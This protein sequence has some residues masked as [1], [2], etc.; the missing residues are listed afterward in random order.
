MAPRSS[1]FLSFAFLSLLVFPSASAIKFNLPTSRFPPSKCIWNPAHENALVIVTAN[2]GP[3]AGQRVDIEII[4]SSP[5]KNVYLSKRNINAET[6]LA[7]TTHA[8][9]EVGVCFKN[10]LDKEISQEKA[11]KMSRVVDL[12]VDIGA[13]AVDYNAIA[14]QES[15]SGLETEM[16]KLEGLV[17]EIVDEM[18]YLK[19]RE[20]RFSD[21]NVST[22]QRVQNFAWFTIVSLAGLGPESR[23]HDGA[24]LGFI[25]AIAARSKPLNLPRLPIP[26]LRQTL[27]R[28]LKSLE[29]F[30]LEDEARGGTSFSSAYALRVKWANEFESGVGQLCQ[31]RLLALDRASPHNWLDDNF[32]MNKAY[33]EWRAPLLV[34]SNW[35][36]A[37]E[38][39]AM[40][41]AHARESTPGITPWQVRRAAWLVH[42]L[43]SFKDGLDKQ[44]LYPETTRLGLWLRDS[45]AKMFNMARIPK[46]SCDILSKPPSAT[47]PDG[48]KI[49][50]MIHNWCYAMPIYEL[51]S[52]STL[53]DVGEIERRMRSIVIDVERRLAEGETAFP[54]GVLTA[55][56]RDRWTENL[57]HLLSL[58]SKNQKSHRIMCQSLLG[59][60]LDHIAASE[61]SSLT[62][63]LHGTRSTVNNVSNRIF[64]KTFTLMV[65]P[66]TRAGASG[67]HA[68]CD[69][70]VP[71]IVAEWALV[72]SVDPSAFE[73]LEPEPFESRAKP[74]DG[75]ERLDWDVDDQIR[76]E[77]DGALDRAKAIIEDSDDDVFWFDAY[78]TDWIKSHL[79]QSPDAYVQLALQL[80]YYRVRGQFTA[81]YETALTRMFKRGRTE[82]IRSLTRQSRAWVLG[83][84]DD[85]ASVRALSL[86]CNAL[87]QSAQPQTRRNLLHDALHAHSTLT[88]EA[89]TGRGVDRHL[90]GL[91]LMLRPLGGEQAPL[92][93]D[94]LFQRSQTWKLSTS[95]LSAGN[96]FKGTGFGAS[97][98]DG[99]GINYLAAPDMIKFGIESKVSSPHT[100]TEKFKDASYPIITKHRRT[101]IGTS[102]FSLQPRLRPNWASNMASRHTFA[103]T[104]LT[105][106]A[107]FSAVW[108]HKHHNELSEEERNKP[109]DAI[110]WIHIFLQAAVWGVLFPVGMV[111]GI[112]RSRWH[113]P[114]QSAGIVLTAGGYILGH[115]HK[116]RPF[117]PSAHGSFAD[118]VLIPLAAQIVLGVYLKLHIHE[119]TTLRVWAVRLHGIVGK[120]YPIFGWTQMLFGAI[121][122]RGYCRGGHL[123]QC[124][125]HY[126][127]GSGFIA[128]AVIMVII[129]LVGEAW[130]RRSGRS[131]EWWDSWVIMVWGVVNTFTEHRGS[132]WSVKD[133]QH[134]I[135]GVLWWAGGLL[136]ILLARNNKRNVVPAIILILTGW[137]MSEHAQALMISTKV[138]AMFGITLML[139]GVTR[140]GEVCFF[141]GTTRPLEVLDDDS[142]SDHTLAESSSRY[143]TAPH[144]SDLSAESAKVT[145]G[146]AFRHMPPMFLVGAGLLFMSATDEELEFVHNNEMD[147]VTYVL[148][149][150]SIAFLLYTLIVFV[151]SLYPSTG[152]NA[153]PKDDLNNIPLTGLAGPATPRKWYS[154]VPNAEQNAL[155]VIG[156]D[157]EDE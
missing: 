17:K 104:V 85:N 18:G 43:L 3:G 127:M 71:S 16:R 22:Q 115:S 25:R 23:D 2:V 11:A 74:D 155:H 48:L 41:P 153:A 28:Y 70:L 5:Q 129:L 97:Y 68:P 44:E 141:P 53:I 51:G 83:M 118:I 86:Q 106:S 66:S 105:L 130:V 52:P 6:R 73:S 138:H 58:S 60:S 92:F 39:D 46:P 121:A 128:Y 21:T 64:D 80:A 75:W 29:P 96:L 154:R 20:E 65:D 149:M 113:V 146:K 135:L 125:A 152:R 110:L 40:I 99:Y 119:G 82:T 56:D 111:L 140:I 67:E 131:P 117:L 76:S 114:L 27:D 88:R 87:Q 30:L 35:W 72:E 145:L 55:D 93:E 69:A 89:M 62:S 33:L 107:C 10:H 47:N 59:V 91:R 148:I 103:F 98:D 63:H 36:L 24:L 57:R 143:P 102:R 142:H 157:E 136:G 112:T 144:S 137:A 78:G 109:V 12:D 49:Y 79:N 7:I 133:M 4:D 122:F 81:T 108:A 9:G 95:G 8:E 14:N 100:S 32:W 50:L 94:E 150:Y 124:L 45:T 61:L 116:G 26:T 123:P 13:E 19:K 156:E 120:S 132:N 54:I 77:C 1:L 126:I 147:H 151:V 84:V 15:L 139:A 90:L 42:R 37:F 134:T 38:D 101:P 31:E 34:N